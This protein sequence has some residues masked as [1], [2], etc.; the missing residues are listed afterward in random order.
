MGHAPQHPHNP[1]SLNENEQTPA[2]IWEL[3][4]WNEEF[5]RAVIKLQKFDADEKA[6]RVYG[7]E[8]TSYRII[9]AL[10]KHNDFAAHALQ[11]LVPDPQFLI[12]RIAVPQKWNSA[13]RFDFDIVAIGHGTTPDPNDQAN[14]IW[15]NRVKDRPHGAIGESFSR[16]PVVLW[17]T[18]NDPRFCSKVDPL[19]EW[20]EFFEVNKRD[21]TLETPWRE[22]PPGFRRDFCRLWRQRDSR[23]VSLDTGLRHDAPEPRETDFFQNWHFGQAFVR[24]CKTGHMDLEAIARSFK[25]DELANDYRVFAFPKCIRSRMAARDMAEWL[26]EQ[27]TA[28]LPAREPEFYGSPLQWDIFLTVKD[29]MRDRASLNEALQD[30]FD[31][32][33]LRGALDDQGQPNQRLLWGQRGADWQNNYRAIDAPAGGTGFLQRIFPLRPQPQLPTSQ[34][35]IS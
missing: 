24:G 34:V 27:L 8:R 11:W 9:Q 15:E 20:R 5:S 23:A 3:L 17:Q 32:I 7:L 25:F 21:F 2:K 30:S 12:W 13:G 31:K 16:G 26:V 35:S 10:E 14:W 22:A 33:H 28:N 1:C 18:C 19:Q 6:N 4:R 29:L